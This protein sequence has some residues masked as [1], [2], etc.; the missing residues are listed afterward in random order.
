MKRGVTRFD[1]ID[2]SYAHKR[3]ETL[4]SV[5]LEFNA[6]PAVPIKLKITDKSGEPAAAALD[7]R[8]H[9]GRVYPDRSKRLAPDFFFHPQVYRLDGETIYLPAESTA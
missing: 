1:W 2:L 8:D 3:G 7:I 5:P 9:L 6:A 4:A